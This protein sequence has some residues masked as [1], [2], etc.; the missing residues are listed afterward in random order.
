MNSYNILTVY[1]LTYPLCVA[2]MKY[3]RT[4]FNCENLLIA[5]CELLLCSQ[6]LEMQLYIYSAPH[7]PGEKQTQ[8][9]NSHFHLQM[10]KRSNE[11]IHGIKTG[12]TV[13]WL[14]CWEQWRRHQVAYLLGEILSRIF[15]DVCGCDETC[16]MQKMLWNGK[17]DACTCWILSNTAYCLLIYLSE[18]TRIA[19]PFCVLS[20]DL[21]HSVQHD[22]NIFMCKIFAYEEC[23]ANG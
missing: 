2:W 10:T 3:R 9:I 4:G 13:F 14:L 20:W 18:K 19:S 17:Y 21:H 6:L 1:I 5:N 8:S 12:P 15:H 22:D 16:G 11:W 7:E 23:V